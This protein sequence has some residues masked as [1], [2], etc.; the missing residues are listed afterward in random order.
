[1]GDGVEMMVLDGP[2]VRLELD[3]LDEPASTLWSPR[4]ATAKPDL[5]TGLPAGGCS[6]RPRPALSSSTSQPTGAGPR[7]GPLSPA[8]ARTAPPCSQPNDRLRR[9]YG[10]LRHPSSLAGHEPQSLSSHR[11]G[12]SDDA[13]SAATRRWG[14]RSHEPGRT[15]VTPRSPACL[16][17]GGGRRDR[18]GARCRGGCSVRGTRDREG[19]SMATAAA[20][21]AR[22]VGDMLSGLAGAAGIVEPRRHRP[23]QRVPGLRRRRDREHAPQR[24][25]AGGC[26]P[27][28]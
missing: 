5:I 11:D 26:R 13:P 3:F 19:R 16:R 4:H 9:D 18:R 12:S 15:P 7:A 24:R 23:A 10:T 27:G 1:M 6:A 20:T 22:T 21:T 17:G 8:L 14:R 25:R 28:R 2:G